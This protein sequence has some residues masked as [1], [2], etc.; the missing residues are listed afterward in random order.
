MRWWRVGTLLALI[1]GV[2]YFNQFVVPSLPQPFTPTT[3]PTQDPAYH[4]EQADALFAAGKLEE[5]AA[6][7]GQAIVL[8]PTRVEYHV[9]LARIQVFAGNYEQALLAAQDAVLLDPNS[10]K[11][12][13]VRS[14]ALA[15]DPERQEE[16]F[17]AAVQ[18]LQLDP[19]YALAHAY[20]AEILADRYSTD[21]TT[22]WEDAAHEARR[23]LELAPSL[24]ESHRAMGYV[25]EVTG[26][27]DQAIAEYERALAIHPNLAMLY[28]HLGLNYARGLNDV[29]RAV[30]AYQKGIALDPDDAQ[31]YSLTAQAYASAGE[32]GK[33]SQYAEQAVE[34]D[35]TEP[36][37][38]G[39]LGLM[40]YHSQEYA[41]AISE[42]VL[43]TQGGTAQGADGLLVAVEPLPLDYGRSAEFY[44][45]LGLALAKSGRCDQAT[46]IFEAIR[47]KIPD[48]EIATFNAE[49]GLRM[50]QETTTAVAGGGA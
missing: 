40:Y 24:V 39:Q 27:Y 50:C 46:P 13:A 22:N 47:T 9:A 18:A 28:K 25:Y 31:L 1:G 4:A 17:A 32:Y 30:E 6:A 44:F 26:N 11:A 49:E 33:A 34:L 35:A 36:R 15:F 41:A 45:T 48:D 42:L 19:N 29:Q 10:A 3:T 14:W 8:D 12:H 43:A 37:Y 16:A 7:Y 21:P 20:F 38:H 23:A 2:W 5:A